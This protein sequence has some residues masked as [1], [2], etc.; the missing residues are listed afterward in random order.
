MDVTT[1][2]ARTMVNALSDAR[3]NPAHFINT[4]I[5]E[6]GMV[7][8]AQMNLLNAVLYYIQDQRR[9]GELGLAFTPTQK[10]AATHCSGMSSRYLDFA[11][12]GKPLPSDSPS[13][14]SRYSRASDSLYSAY[15]KTNLGIS[16]TMY[17]AS[18]E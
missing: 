18:G 12:T 5:L 15:P 1:R 9:Q 16:K 8:V 11:L 7:E 3:F 17:G 4:V 13:E 14:L 6:S 10:L 2:A